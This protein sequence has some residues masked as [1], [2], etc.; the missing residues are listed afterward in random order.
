MQEYYDVCPSPLG[1]IY[2]IFNSRGIKRVCLSKEKFEKGKYKHKKNEEAR[3]QLQEYFHGK[4]RKFSLPLCLEGTPFQK[5]VWNALQK[6]P[7][8]ETC[9]Y[10]QIAEEIG[11][12]KA[13]RAVGNAI[14]ANPLP[15]IIPCHRVI[16]KNGELGGY[17][18]GE[19]IK[20]KLL[21]HEKTQQ[22]KHL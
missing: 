4:R 7:Y 9:F 11:K 15:I 2:I 22:Q 18:G 20:E 13:S 5:K 10:Q 17:S 16:K 1:N 6:I 21:K 3:K 14:G 12:P 19:G 8:G